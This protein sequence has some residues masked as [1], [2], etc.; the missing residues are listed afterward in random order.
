MLLCINLYHTVTSV[1][2]S[3]ILLSGSEVLVKIGI[4]G[5]LVAIPPV[6]S[7]AISRFL[8]LNTRTLA[9]AR[10]SPTASV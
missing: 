5:T 4:G 3:V 6:G 1:S 7:T 2:V 8:S 9:L 10:K